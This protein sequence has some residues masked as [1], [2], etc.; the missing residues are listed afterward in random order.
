M[1]VRANKGISVLFTQNHTWSH[2]MVTQN[3][4]LCLEKLSITK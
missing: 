1:S 2:K 3:Q 4:G